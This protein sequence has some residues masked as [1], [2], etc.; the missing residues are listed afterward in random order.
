M[1]K[2]V[3]GKIAGNLPNY[4][5]YNDLVEYGIIGLLDAV[6]KYDVTKNINFKTYAV[7]RVRGSVYDELRV[8]DWVPRSVRKM[9]K[10]IE[11][12]NVELEK[13]LKRL[14]REAEIAE[15]LNVT[16]K[17]IDAVFA[18]VNI[19]HISSLDDIIY[20]S[21]DSTT[22]RGETIENK[23]SGNAHEKLEKDEL[24]TALMERL[25]ELSEKERMIISL[26]YYEELT[27]KEIGS[28]LGISE[29]RVSQIHSKAVLKL[30]SKL[31]AK[32]GEYKG[33]I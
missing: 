3:V 12:A 32:F 5:D 22:S 28:I 24:K 23:K 2:Y 4:V 6:D 14:P 27:L 31:S 19:G 17:E 13:K 29:S 9:A 33:I 20:G 18:K 30:R 15:H 1:V 8:Q 11:K 16:P 26:Y 21:D 7:T 10:D 25:K